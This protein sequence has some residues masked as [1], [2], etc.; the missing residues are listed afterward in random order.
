MNK[1]DFFLNLVENSQA[2]GFSFLTPDERFDEPKRGSAGQQAIVAMIAG[3]AFGALGGLATG[4]AG[5]LNNEQLLNDLKRMSEYCDVTGINLISGM[6][7]LRLAIDADEIKDDALIGRFALIHERTHDFRKYGMSLFG[8]NI[9]TATHVIVTFSS[10]ER[11]Q[12][13]AKNVAKKCK[14]VS[15]WKKVNTRPWVADLEAEE[16]TKFQL[17]FGVDAK[18]LKAGLFKKRQ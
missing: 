16:I 3:A 13:F 18:E 11:A 4:Y 8:G 15:F 17:D 9:G 6:V 14:Q 10:H 7:I 12:D 1:G 2:K 5:K